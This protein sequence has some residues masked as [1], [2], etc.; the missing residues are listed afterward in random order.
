MSFIIKGKTVPSCC[1]ACNR[2]LAAIAGCIYTRR[3]VLPEEHDMRSGRHPRCPLVALPAHDRLIQECD[4]ALVIERLIGYIDAD[5][6]E[7]VK[8]YIKIQVPTIFEAEPEE[9]LW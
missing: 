9:R 4:V 3:L 2:D 7:R 8:T 1:A 6:V 5:M